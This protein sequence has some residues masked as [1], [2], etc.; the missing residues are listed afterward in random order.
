MKSIDCIEPTL[1]EVA[2]SIAK[3]AHNGQVDKAGEPYINHPARVCLSRWCLGDEDRTVVALLHDVLED[4]EI[5]AQELIDYG[6]P[7]HLVQSVQCLTRQPNESYEDFIERCCS[8]SIAA[9]VKL[10]DLEDNLDITRLNE[11]NEKDVFRLNKYLRARRRI[12][13]FL[14]SN[15]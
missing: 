4:S 12:I 11:I 13:D 6:I 10:A 3:K 8:D 5:T 7:E 1:I 15:K 14:Q 2:F 9:R